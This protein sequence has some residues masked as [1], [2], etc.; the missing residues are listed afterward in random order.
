[1]A[2]ETKR[3]CMTVLRDLLTTPHVLRSESREVDGTGWVRVLSYPELGVAV[4][5]VV[6]EELYDALEAERLWHLVG[7]VAAGTIRVPSRPSVADP[8]IAM[9]LARAGLEQWIACL[10]VE[11]EQLALRI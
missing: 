2:P 8:G 1:M 3:R 6:M 4:Q 7:L 9:A 10:D 11:L 5:G